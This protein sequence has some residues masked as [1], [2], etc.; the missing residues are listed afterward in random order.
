ML[1]LKMG[2]ARNNYHLPGKRSLTNRQIFK[3]SDRISYG[4][5]KL[6][7][8]SIKARKSISEMISD[9]QK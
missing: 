6:E 9:A 2:E 7:P 8:F 3:T 4:F 5:N 1:F